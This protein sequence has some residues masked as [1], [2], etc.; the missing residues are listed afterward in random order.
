[1]G[2]RLGAPVLFTSAGR[3]SLEPTIE[4]LISNPLN[5]GASVA[6]TFDEWDLSPLISNRT[7]RGSDFSNPW[8]GTRGGCPY[9]VRNRAIKWTQS[10]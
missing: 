2:W 4:L 9:S 10:W 3:E 8:L 7:L 6:P 1:V 5:L